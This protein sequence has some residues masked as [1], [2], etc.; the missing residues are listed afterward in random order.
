[1]KTIRLYCLCSVSNDTLGMNERSIKSFAPG[2]PPQTRIT[3]FVVN[4]A[5]GP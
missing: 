1:M 4:R 2:P 3:F 5:I